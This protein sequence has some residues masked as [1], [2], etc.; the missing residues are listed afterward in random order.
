MI[1]VKGLEE[2]AIHNQ[3]HGDDEE[4]VGDEAKHPA[5]PCEAGRGNNGRMLSTCGRKSVGTLMYVTL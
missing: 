1:A 5:L 4:E 3:Q 2:E